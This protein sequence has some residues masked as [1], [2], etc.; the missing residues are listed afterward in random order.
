[1][2]SDLVLSR[3]AER[4]AARRQRL[5]GAAASRHHDGSGDLYNILEQLNALQLAAAKDL[6]E[7]IT[8]PASIKT[9]GLRSANARLEEVQQRLLEGAWLLPAHELRQQQSAAEALQEQVDAEVSK[10]RPRKV[11]SLSNKPRSDPAAAAAALEAMAK[12]AET[13]AQAANASSTSS[14]AAPKPPDTTKSSLSTDRIIRGHSSEKLVR[15]AGSVT[16]GEF[17]VSDLEGCTVLLLA[18][19]ST[20]RLQRLRQCTIA[21]GPVSGSAFLDDLDECTVI[22]AAHQFRC[23]TSRDVT[24]WLQVSSNPVIEDSSRMVFGGLN[25]HHSSLLH[26]ETSHTALERET[27]PKL[28]STAGSHSPQIVPLPAPVPEGTAAASA[29]TAWADVQDFNHVHSTS[30]PNW[31]IATAEEIEQAPRF[32]ASQLQTFASNSDHSTVET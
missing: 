30:S 17:V 28:D 31:R 16:E 29:T 19:L 25:P 7:A 23:H 11:F 26:V 2:S 32:E 4:D 20:L 5:A 3:I 12:Q 6:R 9:I 18:P 15:H 8:Q 24:A 13:A 21:A 27:R 10:A 22:L 1:M 14:A